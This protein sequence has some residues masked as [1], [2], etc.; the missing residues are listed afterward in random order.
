MIIGISSKIGCGKT[1]L[2]NLF[3]EKHPFYTKLS[4]AAILKKECSEMF[5]Y[6]YS[7]NYTEDGKQEIIYDPRFPKKCMTVREILQWYGTDIC[8]AKDPDYWTKKMKDTVLDV[9][10]KDPLVA[11]LGIIIDDARFLNEA[12]WVKTMGGK[13]IR[14]NPYPGWKPGPFANH[15]SETNLDDYKDFDLVLNPKFGELK[16]CL[17]LIEELIKE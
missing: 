11:T 8:R 12:G 5:C 10:M 2:S 16:S 15:K 6:P 9:Y 1:T 13:N 7:W 4:F 17:P 3:I 14:L